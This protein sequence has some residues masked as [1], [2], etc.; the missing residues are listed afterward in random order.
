MFSSVKRLWQSFSK[1]R[2]Q[3]PSYYSIRYIDAYHYRYQEGQYCIDIP[4][5][6]MMGRN[7]DLVVYASTLI[8]W[9]PPHDHEFITDTERELILRKL[10][11]KLLKEKTRFKIEYDPVEVEVRRQHLQSEKKAD[12]LD[13][14]KKIREAKYRATDNED[15][16]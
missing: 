14:Y 1:Q 3:G 10:E 8:H 15:G 11:E 9:N 4:I 16:K 2:A 7:L 12:V 13:L 6:I 5:E